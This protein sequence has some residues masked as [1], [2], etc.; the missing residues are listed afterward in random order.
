VFVYVISSI[1]ATELL[2]IKMNHPFFSVSVASRRP[3]I[4]KRKRIDGYV[5]S[6]LIITVAAEDVVW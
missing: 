4:R 2:L 1:H 5:I 3:V 6:L